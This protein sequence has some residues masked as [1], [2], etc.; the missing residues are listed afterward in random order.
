MDKHT[1]DVPPITSQRELDF[2]S[3]L[4][5]LKGTIMRMIKARKER[6]NGN[7]LP[8]MDTLL[9]SGASEERVLSDTVTF[10]GGFHTAGY[11]M[12][13]TFYFFVQH[14][15]IQERLHKEITERVGGECGEKLKFYTFASNSFLRQV[16]D[17]ALRLSTTAP[18]SAHQYNQDMVVDGYHVPAKTAIIHASGVALK[19]EAVW[20]QPDCFNPDRFA[21][22]SKTCKK[23]P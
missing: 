9:A 7:H 8:F 21:P 16:L 6:K 14:P 17:E 22:G 23:G 3:N 18:F 19:S 5:R 13:W 11:Y 1:L 10:M 2:Q 12:T 15:D 4:R 20:E